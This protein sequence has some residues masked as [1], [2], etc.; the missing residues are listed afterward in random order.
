MPIFNA[1]KNLKNALDSI[2]NQTIGFENIQVIMVNDCSTDESKNI[3]NKYSEKYKNFIS[4]HLKKNTG[5]AYGPRNIALKLATGKYLMFLD[6]D[7]S[8]E[9][10]TCEILYNEISSNDVDIVFARY[11]RIYNEK[12]IVR[13][14]YSPFEDQIDEYEDEFLKNPNFSGILSFL[15]EKFFFYLI[16]GKK[17]RKNSDKIYIPNINEEPSILK[18]LPCIWTKIYK[19]ELIE[20]NNIT[21]PPFISGEDLNFVIESYIHANGILFLNNSFIYNY[22]MRETDENQSVTKKISFKLVIDSLKSYLASSNLCN[23]FDFKYNDLILNPFLLNWIDLFLKFKGSQ[24]QYEELLVQAKNMKKSYKSSLK[25][26]LL[27]ELIILMIKFSI[28][29]NNYL[30][31]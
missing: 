24:E 14:S 23:K 27:I 1:E 19:R 13:K 8:Y 10:D 25:F 17:I 11:K 6:S 26:N 21:F 29:K 28:I 12:N 9:E 5:G 31:N 18:I 20:N 4:I 3:I 7:D 15:W 30:K 16:Y 22:C 2:V